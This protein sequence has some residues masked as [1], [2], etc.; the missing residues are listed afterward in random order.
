LSPRTFDGTNDEIRCSIGACTI[1]TAITL[2]IVARRT[3]TGYS[4]LLALH[5]SG[6]TATFALEVEDNAGG[7]SVDFTGKVDHALTCP[8]TDGWVLLAGGKAAG[9][10]TPRLHKY[11]YSTNAWSHVNAGSTL[12]DQSSVSG[13]TVR[14]GE[15]QDTDDFAGD[16][17][18]A[19]V[20]NRLLTDAELELLPFTLQAWYASAPSGLWLFDQSA[21]TQPIADLT[22]GGANES[23]RTQ[24]TVST[25]SVP[26][27]HVDDGAWPVVRPQGAGGPITEFITPAGTLTS[28]GALTRQPTQA[29]AG[30][31]PSSG[32]LGRQVAQALAGTLTSSGALSQAQTRVLAAAGTLASVG[33]L[34]WQAAVRQAGTLSSSGAL[35]RQVTQ[36]LAGALPSSGALVAARVVLLTVAGTVASAGAVAR[37]AT[38]ALAGTLPSSGA[39]AWHLATGWA[40]TVPSSGALSA[41]RVVLLTVAGTLASSGAGVWRAAKQLAGTVAPTGA[42]ARALTQAL[43][44]TLPSSGALGRA[45]TQALAGTL[46]SGGGLVRAVRQA[47]AG[48]L[49]ALGALVEVRLPGA[50]PPTAREPTQTRAGATGGGTRLGP[51]GGAT[52]LLVATGGTTRGPATQ[53]W[54][55]AGAPLGGTTRGPATQTWTRAA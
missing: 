48:V 43:A 29:L 2:A 15:W 21:V 6:G 49:A 12:A 23:A 38:Q 50:V 3:S 20:W 53:T 13:G 46:S 4:A 27:F 25:T 44:G 7:N 14:F 22:G 45:V 34:A 10:S 31:L 51:T 8:T 36:S 41:T 1:T 30:T 35:V 37:Q 52:Q 11:V 28:A 18:V 47:V 26:L 19:A 42:L 39:V 24:T 55:R 17:A 40:G 5:T 54:T 16:L 32:A 9:T 33:A